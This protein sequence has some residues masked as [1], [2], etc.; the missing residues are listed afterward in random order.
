[1]SAVATDPDLASE[2]VNPQILSATLAG[3]QLMN[4]SLILGC[5]IVLLG[6]RVQYL[7][8]PVQIVGR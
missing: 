1:M 4:R 8:R 2:L 7:P 5:E 6:M 3:H